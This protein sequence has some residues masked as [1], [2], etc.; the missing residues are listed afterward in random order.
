M[1]RGIKFSLQQDGNLRLV[2]D[3]GI[4]ANAFE[5]VVDQQELRRGVSIAIEAIVANLLESNGVRKRV[6]ADLDRLIEIAIKKCA[7][8]IARKAEASAAAVVAKRVHDMIDLSS[9]RVDVDFKM[10][11]SHD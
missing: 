10:G 6:E 4:D 5:F 7:A 8:D 2:K 1:S 9:I 11:G 3:N